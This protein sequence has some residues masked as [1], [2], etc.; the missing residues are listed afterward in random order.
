MLFSPYLVKYYRKEEEGTEK[1]L[2][3]FEYKLIFQAIIT[4]RAMNVQR[5]HGGNNIL[6]G[7][8]EQGEREETF[9][10]Q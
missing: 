4:K 2:P 5:V 8:V 6:E 1:D 10:I 3:Y 9:E 7:K